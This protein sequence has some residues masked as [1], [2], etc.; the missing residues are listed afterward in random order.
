MTGSEFH[1]S[2]LLGV[3]WCCLE[4]VAVDFPGSEF[5]FGGLRVIRVASADTAEHRL[6][7]PPNVVCSPPR[8]GR[9]F[10]P[11]DLRPSA[12]QEPPTSSLRRTLAKE[13]RNR[14]RICSASHPVRRIV[15]HCLRRKATRGSLAESRRQRWIQFQ[16][17]FY[18]WC[19]DTFQPVRNHP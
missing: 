14:C 16:T 6:Q 13:I 9:G 12:Q 15:W 8:Y 17:P 10:Q 2:A 19:S 4:V 5:G 18:T 1:C 3:S 11:L 7:R